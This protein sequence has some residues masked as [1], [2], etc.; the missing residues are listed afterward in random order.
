MAL[1]RAFVFYSF[2][3]YYAAAVTVIPLLPS[4]PKP[5]ESDQVPVTSDLDLLSK[6]HAGTNYDSRVLL[7]SYFHERL[8]NIPLQGIYPS[9]D[10]FLRGAIDAVAKHQH[11]IIQPEDVW[12]TILKQLS[13]YL[14]KHKDDQEVS[15]AWD[16]LEGKITPPMYAL[17]PSMTMDPWMKKQFDLRSKASWLAEWVLPNFETVSQPDQPTLL[18]NSSVPMLANALMM[19]SSSPASEELLAFPCINGL[20]SVTLNGTKEDWRSILKKVDSL[21]QFGKEP[22]HYGRLLHVILSRFVAT[23]DKPND[24]AI[25]L[26]WNDIVTA[27]PIQPLCRTTDHITGW[28]NAFYM[29]NAAGDIAV[30]AAAT[31][32]NQTVQIDGITFPWRHRRDVP[33]FY[34]HSPMCM[35]TERSPW[36]GHLTLGGM[37]AKSVKQGKPKDYDAALKLAGITLPSSVTEKDHS[38]LKPL[39]IWLTFRDLTVICF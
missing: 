5:Y 24:P 38:I 8:S 27:T 34:S 17:F 36:I 11:L 22:K 1:L 13:T 6:L 10:G 2:L 15:A 16:N 28:I 32:Q 39:P 23:F 21:A 14:R 30:T 26:F 12:I 31:S 9:Q 29:W 3:S 33:T 25:R 19:A 20:P 4:L 37:L 35:E 7:S 18:V